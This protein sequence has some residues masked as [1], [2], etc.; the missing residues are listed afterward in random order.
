VTEESDGQLVRLVLA[1]ET[2]VYGRL[3]ERYRDRLGRYAVRM[4]GNQADA[5]E[6]L[7]D[8]F[9]RGYRYLA[10]CTRPE[11]FGAWLFGI[12]VNRCRTHAAKRARREE[13]LVSDD[14][15]S[16]P[17]AVAGR[18]EEQHAWRDT[19]AWA[20]EQLPTDQREAFLLRH[21]EDRTY[22]EMEE[23][24][25]ARPATL[26]MRVFRAREELR[27]LLAEVIHE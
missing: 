17:G 20:M 14:V 4:L 6:A 16:T 13:V 1:G 5:E 3:V 12:L 25:G 2:E 27:R 11:G 10:R 19:I 8:A 18:A 21:V 24:T 23:L 7:Q 26:R 9:V 22:E 15:V